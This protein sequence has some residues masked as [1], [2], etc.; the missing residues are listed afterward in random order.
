MFLAGR[1][2]NGSMGR[3]GHQSGSLMLGTKGLP[4]GRSVPQFGEDR[5]C[6]ESPCDT[7]LSRYNPYKRCTSH[8]PARFRRNRGVRTK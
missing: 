5:I 7:V 1:T 6:A 4:R 2:S 3:I 8:E